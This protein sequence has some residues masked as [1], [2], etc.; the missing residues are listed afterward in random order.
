MPNKANQAQLAAWGSGCEAD[1]DELRQAQSAFNAAA[2]GGPALWLTRREPPARKH[3]SLALKFWCSV[4]RFASL[5]LVSRTPLAAVAARRVAV[6][7][8]ALL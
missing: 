8:G 3:R 1:T 5:P 7:E 4:A 2:L 6:L